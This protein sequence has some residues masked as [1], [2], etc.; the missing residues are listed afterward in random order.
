MPDNNSQPQQA[1]GFL[2]RVDGS[3]LSPEA[4]AD[5]ISVSILEDL[6]AP[7]MFEME[8]LNWDTAKL[9]MKWS[10]EDLFKPGK[11]TEIDLGYGDKRITLI[12]GESTGLELLLAEKDLPRL[13]VRGYDRGHRLLRGRTTMTYTNMKDSD[14]A[15]QVASDA[16]LSADVEDTSATLS[17]VIQHNQSD[18]EF[19]RERAARIGYE[20]RVQA[21]QL[22]FR[23]RKNDQGEALTLDRERDLLEFY[24]RLTTVNQ[25]GGISVRAWD[26]KQKQSLVGQAKV[27]D[28]G[29]KMGGA[30]AGP[31]VANWYGDT[32]ALSTNRPVSSQGEAD[33]LAAALLNKVALSHISGD[34][35]CA[36]RT[37]L[38]AGINVKFEG[39][40]T[41]FSGLYYVRS[42]THRYTPHAGYR[43]EFRVE[44]NAS[45]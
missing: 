39:L 16:G 23:A 36:G 1:P 26:P 34:G 29:N 31:A 24:P 27:S 10:D 35:V 14:I 28:I 7:A 5:V 45:G 3:E 20:V 15:N 12:S 30:N 40:G 9:R 8:M 6:E 25:I 33:K 19:L 41:R 44:R 17:Y 32:A 43:T 4:A 2:I 18:L 42:T 13:V 22:T 11:S 21:K 38:R 37:D